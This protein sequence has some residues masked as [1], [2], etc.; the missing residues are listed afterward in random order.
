MKSDVASQLQR[1]SV[2]LATY[3]GSQYMGEQLESLAQQSLPPREIVVTDEGSSDGTVDLVR[4]FSKRVD[5][6]VRVYQ[7]PTRLGFADNFMRAA[8]LCEGPLIAFCDQDDVWNDGKLAACSQFFDDPELMLCVHSSAVWDGKAPTGALFPHFAETKVH[9]P[10]SLDPF[11][12][13]PGFSMV[14]RSD[15]LKLG[16]KRSRIRHLLNLDPKAQMHH[17]SWIWL[18]GMYS[19]KVATIADSLA[20]Y[21]QHEANTLGVPPGLSR[22]QALLLTLSDTDYTLL[23]GFETELAEFLEDLSKDLRGDARVRTLEASKRF[24]RLASFHGLRSTIYDQSSSLT[25]RGRSFSQL[26]MKGGYGPEDGGS[27]LGPR[28]AVKDLLFG[29]TAIYRLARGLKPT[30]RVTSYFGENCRK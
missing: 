19:G 14:F 30:D 6:P 11:F 28:A 25:K 4:A 26:A 5:F 2:A 21:R 22:M 9:G 23:A 27:A 12:L 24:E 3:N 16:A 18:L 7:N 20:L 8:S 15:L 10:G 1:I 29:V 13:I 17:D